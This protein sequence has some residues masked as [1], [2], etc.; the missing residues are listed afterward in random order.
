MANRV[1]NWTPAAIE[2]EGQPV[3]WNTTP[4]A[5]LESSHS[6]RRTHQDGDLFWLT[7]TKHTT[8]I[9]IKIQCIFRYNIFY[10]FF[11]YNTISCLILTS[12]NKFFLM[13][14]KVIQEEID[15]CRFHNFHS[16]IIDCTGITQTVTSALLVGLY[17][18]SILWCS[19]R[20]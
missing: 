18:S 7:Y 11:R 13:Q 10:V 2:A 1:G 6:G 14:T 20:V 12:V 8:I 9:N 17:S 16:K 4:L 3:G 19:H 15:I 5:Q